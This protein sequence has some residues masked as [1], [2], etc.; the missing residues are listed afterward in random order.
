[1]K[2]IIIGIFFFLSFSAFAYNGLTA[3]G[4]INIFP[5]AR[6]LAMGETYGSLSNDIQSMYFNPGG[7]G[8]IQWPEISASYLQFIEGIRYINMNTGHISRP[9]M[10][11]DI[12]TT[13]GDQDIFVQKTEN[14]QELGQTEED[15][16]FWA[17]NTLSKKI[18]AIGLL[19]FVLSLFLPLLIG[20]AV[21][22][23]Y[24]RRFRTKN[25]IERFSHEDYR[26]GKERID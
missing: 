4:A 10:K 23:N 17:I 18:F 21:R 22:A 9:V 6:A 12:L 24:V 1:M 14:P 15:V 11:Y 7:L 20:R 25:G 2:K 3:D 16:P 13:Q 5:S 26:S 8:L 19:A